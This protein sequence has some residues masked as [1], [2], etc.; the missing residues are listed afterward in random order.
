MLRDVFF[1]SVQILILVEQHNKALL[2]PQLICETVSMELC[3]F[4]MIPLFQ[5]LDCSPYCSI[6]RLAFSPPWKYIVFDKRNGFQ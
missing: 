1:L 2:R 6:L 4:E 5:R 3:G